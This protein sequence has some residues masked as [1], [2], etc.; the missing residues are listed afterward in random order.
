VRHPCGCG[1]PPGSSCTRQ[2][3]DSQWARADLPPINDPAHARRALASRTHP[4]T[5]SH[6]QPPVPSRHP[7]LS[8]TSS[9]HLPN[10]ST[11]QLQNS[12][13]VAVQHLSIVPVPPPRPVLWAE[14]PRAQREGQRHR[15]Q[16][17]AAAVG[18]CCPGG[19]LKAS[20]LE[21][22]KLNLIIWA[23]ACPAGAIS[24]RA[25]GSSQQGVVDGEVTGV[26]AQRGVSEGLRK[27]WGTLHTVSPKKE[28]WPPTQNAFQIQTCLA[29]L[30]A[31]AAAAAPLLLRCCTHRHCQPRRLQL[32]LGRYSRSRTA[33]CGGTLPPG[34][35][36]QP[37]TP[38]RT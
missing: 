27:I 2:R 36:V 22:N 8:P 13:A 35:A 33:G 18:G 7:F 3:G 30:P 1:T 25:R 19:G 16:Q 17:G 26:Q 38:R 37:P 9:P 23:K 32:A 15:Q 29:H 12:P 28:S 11:L 34:G 21:G 31:A 5:H 24:K 4:P 14:P 10:S 6:R 20:Q